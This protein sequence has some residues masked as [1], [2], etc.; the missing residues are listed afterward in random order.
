M[1]DSVAVKSLAMWFSMEP[2][3]LTFSCSGSLFSP[4]TSHRFLIS[5][6][7]PLRVCVRKRRSIRCVS[8]K[9]SSPGDSSSSPNFGLVSTTE[10]SDGSVLFRFG[11]VREATR[12]DVEMVELE[13]T[14]DDVD[15]VASTS[16]SSDHKKE[17]AG[18]NDVD[19]VASTSFSSDHKKEVA[20]SNFNYTTKE[21]AESRLVA[22]CRWGSPE[23]IDEEI[24]ST[25]GDHSGMA[26]IASFESPQSIATTLEDARSN[27]ATSD[28]FGPTPD[29]VPRISSEGGL[30]ETIEQEPPPSIGLS[31]PNDVVSLET[32]SIGKNCHDASLTTDLKSHPTKD[33]E[34]VS[35]VEEVLELKT[36]DEDIAP[37]SSKADSLVEV[38]SD[39]PS[40][41]SIQENVLTD[42]TR[43]ATALEKVDMSIKSLSAED[44][45]QIETM[46]ASASSEV[47]S[48]M[49]EKV[50]NVATSIAPDVNKSESLEGVYDSMLFNQDESLE[51]NSHNIQLGETPAVSGE[52]QESAKSSDER[53]EIS[54]TEFCLYPGAASLPHPSKV[55]TGGEDSHFITNRSWLGVADGAGKWS[56][57]GTNA[58]LFAQGLMDNCREIVSAS[59]SNA[60][61]DPVG[62]IIR[63]AAATQ[64][65]GL[66][67]VLVA[68]F[69]GQVLHVANIGNSGF[70]II[71]DGMIYKKS[72]PMAYEFNFPVLIEGGDSPSEL[73]ECYSIELDEGDVV[74]SAT[75]GL[76]D[77]LYEQEIASVVR[78]SLQSRLSPQDMAEILATRGQEMGQSKS[79]RTP[80]ADA[81]HAA[82]YVGYTGGKL[83]DVTVVVSM[84][85]KRSSSRL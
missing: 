19:Q 49:N 30:M 29:Y 73:I 39:S 64:S 23:L 32:I 69:D 34:N 3:S 18:S 65:I 70:I 68:C 57:E 44:S 22:E 74:V 53:E 59:E 46:L 51:L 55:L 25:R 78:K 61:T 79:A 1:I 21:K 2:R 75:D 52:E 42:G 10:C 13:G 6:K 7:C 36:V 9:P 12:V 27:V 40:E 80:F 77:N 8:C 26:E 67:T 5:R 60:V 16:F 63:G 47:E 31:E 14:G 11:D 83:D 24:V 82:G 33:M 38:S 66:S 71:R 50:G 56:I 17:V 4:C 15:Q 48:L 84:V 37:A 45:A 41:E 20:S 28:S 76:F 58:G 81:A 72:S 85:E 43:T 54:R 62:V 35:D